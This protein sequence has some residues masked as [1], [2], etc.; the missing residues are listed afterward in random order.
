METFKAPSLDDVLSAESEKD[1]DAETYALNE[2]AQATLRDIFRDLDRNHDGKLQIPEIKVS[3]TSIAEGMC[4][5]E[6]HSFLLCRREKQSPISSLLT[7]F[8]LPMQGALGSVGLPR[9]QEY[10]REILKQYDRNGDG[11][12][13]W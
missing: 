13:D 3:L 10:L 1:E 4:V 8:I 6:V 9:S 7:G 2:S 11:S 12:I 5:V